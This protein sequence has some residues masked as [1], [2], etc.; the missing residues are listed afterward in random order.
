MADTSPLKR[1]DSE[2]SEDSPVKKFKTEHDDDDE[3]EVDVL[4]EVSKEDVADDPMTSLLRSPTES[5][6][7]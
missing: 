5:I 6:S 1:K 3:E 7:K 2:S 4:S